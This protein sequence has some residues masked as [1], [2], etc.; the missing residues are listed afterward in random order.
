METQSV[1]SMDDT[2]AGETVAQ[3]D[4]TMAALLAVLMAA[5]MVGM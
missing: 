3:M 5:L 4:E 2:E 1:A